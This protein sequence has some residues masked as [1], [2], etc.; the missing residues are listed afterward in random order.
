MITVADAFGYEQINFYGVSYGTMLGQHLLRDHEDRIRSIV[1]DAVVPLEQ[2]FVPDVA[3]NAQNALQGIFD[4]CAAD[5]FCSERYSDL[6]AMTFEAY[7]ALNAEPAMVPI[8]DTETGESYD[9]PLTGDSFLGFLR[10]FQYSTPLLP[11]VPAFIENTA[12]GDYEWVENLYGALNLTL[13]RDIAYGMYYGV[14]CAED[15]DFTAEDVLQDGLE[16][17]FLNSS[18]IPITT[19][20]DVCQV[21]NVELLDD[22][23][24]DPVVSDVPALIFS[25]E[26]D[27]VTPAS[28]GD[29]LAG[30]LPNSTH[31]VF[32]GFGHGAISAGLCPIDIMTSFVR[33]PS[34]TPDASC[35]DSLSLSFNEYTIDPTGRLQFPVPT[36]LTDTSTDDF[37]QYQTEA[38]DLIFSVIAVDTLDTDEAA[39][40]ALSAIVR[41]GFA[42]PPLQ[43]I[44]E[45]SGLGDFFTNIYQDG[46]DLIITFTGQREGVTSVVVMQFG[47][48]QFPLAQTLLQEVALSILVVD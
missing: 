6:E 37:A 8:I 5:A 18:G 42:V 4:T 21:A 24:D 16:D 15:G 10:L 38:G 35:A 47:A 14:I 41:D 26:L 45:S 29:I 39:S 23:V 20:L 44:T 30:N 3:I 36:G 9:L 28:Y 12:E 17:P 7:E 27:P 46:T 32:S 34:A 40:E 2:N 43:S 22:Y 33:D 48:T 13:Q 25:G 11:S 31:I 19:V 1:F